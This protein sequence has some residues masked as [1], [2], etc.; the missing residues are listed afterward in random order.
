LL[1]LSAFL[2]LDHAARAQNTPAQV[3]NVNFK[4]FAADCRRLLQGLEA[5]KAPLPADTRKAVQK[6]L[7]AGARQP[8]KAVAEIQKLLDRRCLIGVSINPESRVKA[9]RGLAPAGLTLDRETV[10][11][12]KIHNEAGV[13]H[14]L[15]VSGPELRAKGKTDKG[16][17]LEAAVAAGRPFRKTLSG[18]RLEYVAVKL[19]ARES[20]KR[21]ATLRFDVGQGTQDL[22]F[23]AEV[24]VLFKVKKG[25]P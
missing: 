7:D 12:I 18:Q 2:L 20:G 8:D 11:L 19:V 14:A 10:V 13:T 3:D 23:R 21:E 22:G 15:E 1:V 5:L 4:A 6:W 9:V 16:R 17:W 24:P 25:K